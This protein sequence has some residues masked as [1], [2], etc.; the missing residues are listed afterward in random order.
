MVRVR[1]DETQSKRLSFVSTSIL[2]LLRLCISLILVAY[3]LHRY[4]STTMGNTKYI[5][6]PLFQKERDCPKAPYKTLLDNQAIGNGGDQPSSNNICI[7]TLT[8]T[9]NAD[10]WQRLIRWRNFDSLLE[11]TWEN[12]KQYTEMHGYRLFDESHILDTSRPPSWSKVKAVQRLLKEEQCE[13]VF[14]MDADTIIMNPNKRLESFL[15]L[16]HDFV[17]TGSNGTVFNANAGV[18]AIK[19][20]PWSLNFLERWYNLKEFVRPKGFSQSGDNH[21]LNHLLRSIGAAKDGASEFADHVILG[22]SCAFNTNPVFYIGGE[23]TLRKGLLGKRYDKHKEEEL[24][25][26]LAI[27]HKGDFVAHLGGYSN[28]LELSKMLLG[29]AGRIDSMS[30]TEE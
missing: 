28:K 21:A 15:P 18:W 12:K 1:V 29:Y 25:N 5:P 23:P 30:S 11:I 27:Y 10:I 13:W 4:F 6:S 14:W 7:T 17:V 2:A 26:S 24:V 3:T 22:V 20:S 16:E 19:N 9:K 8:D